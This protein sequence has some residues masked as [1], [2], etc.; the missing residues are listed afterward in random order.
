MKRRSSGS[1]EDRDECPV[2]VP[3]TN[4]SAHTIAK[5]SQ[6]DRRTSLDIRPQS[7]VR[8]QQNINWKHADPICVS[9]SHHAIASA[10][11]RPKLQPSQPPL[12]VAPASTK[13]D[14]LDMDDKTD[15]RFRFCFRLRFRN[16]CSASLLVIISTIFGIALLVGILTSAS[17]RQLDPKGCRM[18]FMRPVYRRLQEFDTEHTRFASKYSLYLYRENGIDIGNKVCGK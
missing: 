18:S 13:E 12:I 2:E 9:D 11:S 4:G 5:D 16:P 17:S 8:R 6:A 3:L 1:T 15:R 10:P 7:C 14:A